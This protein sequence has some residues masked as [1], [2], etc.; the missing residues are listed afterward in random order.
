L[1]SGIVYA[2]ILTTESK[3]YS[4]EI[5][6]EAYGRGFEGIFQARAKDLYGVINGTE[7]KQ[8]D[9]RIDPHIV[10]NY[11]KDEI[12]KKHACKQ[13]LLETCGLKQVPDM[14]LVGM[15]AP[16]DEEKGIDLL[17]EVLEKMAGMFLRFVFLNDGE[18]R[19]QRY[20]KLLSDLMSKH[21]KHIRYYSE[22]DEP[23]KHKIL[24]GADIL[25]MPYKSE[26]CGITQMFALKYGTIPMVYATGGLDDTV[27]EFNP[28]TGKGTGFK[29]TEYTPEALL[30]KLQ[31]VLWIY[32]NHDLWD[33]LQANAMRVNYSW[34]YTAKKYLDLYKLAINRTKT[35]A[36][37]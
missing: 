4:Q 24:A 27:L 9:P 22:N 37:S 1:K 18:R 16:L 11:T 10:V 3:R 5:Q 34:V 28:D 21:R 15:I 20:T 12:E 29:F 26:P 19:E 35:V 13:D 33:L 25:L 17:T 32:H 23:L 2:D 36:V 8:Y 30:T 6:T 7:Y 14:P 31:D